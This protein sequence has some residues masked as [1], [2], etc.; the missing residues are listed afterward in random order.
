MQFLA[1]CFLPLCGILFINLYFFLALLITDTYDKI[2]EKV[3]AKF[4][5]RKEEQKILQTIGSEQNA[6]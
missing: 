5:E 1:D 3:V 2:K 6:L 4:S